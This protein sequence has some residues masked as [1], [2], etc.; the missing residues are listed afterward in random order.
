MKVFME[1]FDPDT[2]DANLPRAMVGFWKFWVHFLDLDP[3][4][5]KNDS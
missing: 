3:K 2:F 1:K 5:E 4:L